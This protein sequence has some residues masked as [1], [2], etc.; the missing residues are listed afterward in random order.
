MSV[1]F[2]F[3]LFPQ[4]LLLLCL[5]VCLLLANDGATYGNSVS[6][7]LLYY[8]GRAAVTLETLTTLQKGLTGTDRQTDMPLNKKES[9]KQLHIPSKAFAMAEDDEENKQT[10]NCH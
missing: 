3:H 4:F 10:K 1:I 6:R 5:F 9:P 7:R 8:L 2:F